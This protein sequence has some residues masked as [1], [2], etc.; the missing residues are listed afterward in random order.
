M[1]GNLGELATMMKKAKD[2][3]ANMEKIRGELAETEFEGSSGGELV[4]AVVTG[5]LRVR[6]I[7]IASGACDDPELLA[8]LVQ[9]AVNAALDNA[10]G[11]M[12][13]KLNE[14]TG[15]I[16]IPGMF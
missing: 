4:S 12:Q 11:T 7:H 9:L 15:G 14:A 1:F 5:D 6:R 8:D 13:R 16:D 2:I 10:K 3:K